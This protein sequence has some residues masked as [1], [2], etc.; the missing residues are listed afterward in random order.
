MDESAPGVDLTYLSLGAG[1]QSSALLVCSALGLHNVPRAA[2][3]IF[4]D[5]QNEPRHVYEQVER[6]RAWSAA[7]GIPVDVVSAGDL[8][9]D[10]VAR[11]EGTR[12]RYASI[13]TWVRGQDG[14]EAPGRRQ[15]TREYKIAPIEQHVRALLGYAKRQR[16]KK[17]ARALIGISVDELVRMKTSR[18]KW[19]ENYYPLV[20]ARLTRADCGRIVES[21][22]LP[23]PRKSACVFCPYTDD[24]RWLDMKTTD[25]ESFAAACA[26]DE[27]LRDQSRSGLVNP[28]YVHRS[29][30]PL[31]DVDFE[32]L[33]AR[34]RALPLF[35]SWSD[36]CEGVCGL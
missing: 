12:S 16:V 3:A 32:A 33:V 4:A 9:A 35:D 13:P 6:L 26:A 30:V 1:V 2:V 11:M 23:M 5:T 8:L 20:R 21:V 31:R 14:L 29:L 24:A 25:P 28:A 17:R 15:C 22:G 19:I 27:A 34:R 7:H 10:A 36:E 18:T